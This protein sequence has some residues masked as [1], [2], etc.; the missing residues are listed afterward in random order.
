MPMVYDTTVDT[1]RSRF[2]AMS[3]YKL[4]FH[5][6]LIFISL[7]EAPAIKAQVNVVTSIRPLQLIAQAI[8]EDRGTVSSVIGALDSPHHYFLTPSDRV[9]LERADLLLWISPGFEVQLADV[10]SSL[11]DVKPIITASDI[12]DISLLSVSSS[13]IDPH[14]WTRSSNGVAIAKALSIRLQELDNA[15]QLD[16]QIALERFEKS[17]NNTDSEILRMTAGIRNKEYLAFHNAY[18]YFQQDYNLADALVLVTNVEVQPSMR[19]LLSFRRKL[20]A[21]SP[22]CILLEPGSN[23]D[24]VDTALGERAIAR[25]VIDLLGFDIED[26]ASSYKKLLLGIAESF[27]SCLSN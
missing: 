2:S 8:I 13:E 17:I 6:I 26:G 3:I 27:Q 15:N 19:E 18:Q 25:V 7:F 23:F 20:E 12:S 22:T 10:F 5:S 11:A 21:L 24:L 16:Y 14:L 4:A 9:N 1:L